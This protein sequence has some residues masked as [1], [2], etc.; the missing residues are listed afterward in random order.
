MGGSDG[1]AEFN[2]IVPEDLGLYKEGGSESDRSC[3]T[4]GESDLSSIECCMKLY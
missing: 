2:R 3:Y 4:E 1:S